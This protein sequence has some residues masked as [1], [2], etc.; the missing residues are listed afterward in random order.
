[1]ARALAASALIALLASASSLAAAAIGPIGVGA[2]PFGLALDASTGRLYVSNESGNSVSVVDTVSGSVVATI[3]VGAAPQSVAVNSA[4]HRVYVSNSGDAS[5]TVLDGTSESVI[6]TLPVGGRGVA[7]DEATNLAYAVSAGAL[8]VVDGASNAVV[9]VVSVPPGGSWSAVAIDSRT[10]RI[11]VS[12]VNDHTLSVLDA[13]SYALVN[14]IWTGGEVRF[15]LIVDVAANRIYAAVHEYDGAL[16]WWDATTY[17]FG[18]AMNVYHFPVGVAAVSSNRVIVSHLGSAALVEVHPMTRTSALTFVAGSS[19]A[20][21]ALSADHGL[22]YLAD[23]GADAVL[24]R[25]ANHPPVIDELALVPSQPTTISQ[26]SVQLRVHDVDDDHWTYTV[27]WFKNGVGFAPPTGVMDLS[28]PGVGDRGDR[29]AAEV[30]VTDG[31]SSVTRTT[32]TVVV[33]NS[34]PGVNGLSLDKF[35]PTT[36]ETLT[37]SFGVIDLDG[38]PVSYMVRWTRN[39]VEIPDAMGPTLNL[40]APGHGDHGDT[41]AVRVTANDT[42]DSSTWERSVVVVNTPPTAAV[43]LNITAPTTI[44][45]LTARAVVHDDDADPITVTYVWRVNGVVRQTME[46]SSLIDQFDL[47]GPRNGQLGDEITV[48]VVPFDGSENGYQ[49]TATA[50]VVA[51]RPNR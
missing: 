5:L 35:A 40:S 25:E 15:G 23:H 50:T 4:T 1:M 29:F 8:S 46:T 21:A 33:V 9:A 24:V 26:L 28:I 51:G 14:T 36:N 10:R 32:D 31:L 12:N 30:T 17:Q 34:P 20:G 48:A 7:V 43:S 38:D 16:W 11:Y 42:I 6:A 19:L 37:A 27:R 41:I 44:D 39:G 45:V 18:G 47:L 13:G 22:L 2:Q 49:A 3:P